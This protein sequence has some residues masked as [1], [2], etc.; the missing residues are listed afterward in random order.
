MQDTQYSVEFIPVKYTKYKQ[1]A[2]KNL[3]AI[4]GRWQSSGEYGGWN[5][6]NYTPQILTTNKA[7]YETA[8][9]MYKMLDEILAFINEDGLTV[10]DL[11]AKIREIKPLLSKARGE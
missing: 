2:P 8:P 3:L 7:M 6:I 1:G 4:G 9:D 5:N 11:P 10:T